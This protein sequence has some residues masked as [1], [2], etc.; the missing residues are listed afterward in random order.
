MPSVADNPAALLAFAKIDNPFIGIL[1]GL[2]GALS[3]NRFQH[4]VLPEWL[5]F[6]SGKRSTVIIA[7]IASIFVAV[8]LLFILPALFT[9]LIQAG[10]AVAG[11]KGM[12]R[13]GQNSVQVV[14][15]PKVQ[16]IA[17][18]LR[19]YMCKDYQQ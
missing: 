8:L 1:A 19:E 17:S 14:I 4:T 15:G 12:I 9:V 16:R 13:P 18:A 6:F 10:Q 11:A 5:A 3:Y 2:I 7:G